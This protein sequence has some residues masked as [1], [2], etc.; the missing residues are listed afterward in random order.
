MLQGCLEEFSRSANNISPVTSRRVPSISN[1]QNLL[2]RPPSKQFSN[3]HIRSHK[4]HR[5]K[6]EGLISQ[7]RNKRGRPAKVQEFWAKSKHRRKLLKLYLCSDL[8]LREILEVLGEIAGTELKYVLTKFTLTCVP[9]SLTMCRLRSTQV[10]L[11]DLLSPGYLEL[12]PQDRANMRLRIDCLRQAKISRRRKKPNSKS[13]SIYAPKRHDPGEELGT[14]HQEFVFEE[15]PLFSPEIYVSSR[16]VPFNPNCSKD[17]DAD[18]ESFLSVNESTSEEKNTGT[19]KSRRFSLERV[20]Q[21]FWSPNRQPSWYTDMHSLLESSSG[22]S[23]SRSTRRSGSSRPGS[24]CSN[25]SLAYSTTEIERPLASLQ[26]TNSRDWIPR[27]PFTQHNNDLTNGCCAFTSNCFHRKIAEAITTN[28]DIF[29]IGH[30]ECAAVDHLGE[31][32]LHAAARWGASL[33]IFERLLRL[34][35][36][37]QRANLRGETFMHLLDH[38]WL[39]SWYTEFIQLIECVHNADFNFDIRSATGRKFLTSLLLKK[40]AFLRIPEFLNDQMEGKEHISEVMLLV[41]VVQSLFGAAVSEQRDDDLCNTERILSSCARSFF[42]DV[43][44]CDEVADF[45]ESELGTRR[46]CD[47]SAFGDTILHRGGEPNTV[48]PTLRINSDYVHSIALL[49]HTSRNSQKLFCVTDQSVGCNESTVTLR[50]LLLDFRSSAIST[51][52]VCARLEQGDNPNEYDK[53]GR[54]CTMSFLLRL[55]SRIIPWSI[56]EPV[57]RL[58][59]TH[60][61]GASLRNQDGYGNTI[62]HQ[63]AQLGLDTACKLLIEVGADVA[64]TNAS[65]ETPLDIA[66][67]QYAICKRKDKRAEFAARHLKTII[68]LLDAGARPKRGKMMRALA[69]MDIHK[70]KGQYAGFF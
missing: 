26:L 65:E 63:A 20:K 53:S 17:E 27:K 18:E 11:C 8:T 49:R 37:T 39:N 60:R 69:T 62:L 52:A 67:A 6:N 70:A 34:H 40:V 44:A 30:E 32:I 43:A 25:Y 3:Q 38:D 5:S 45:L 35:T 48:D 41:E 50:K 29:D 2:A 19:L 59:F 14:A 36:D 46:L 42:E 22:R 28:C 55:R 33:N 1:S 10:L 12:R 21:I 64:L 51:E 15:L 57:L 7:E 58:L 23:S 31:T 61:N 13:P 24:V 68:S 56:G 9:F 4:R 66:V 54:T 16:S 47:T